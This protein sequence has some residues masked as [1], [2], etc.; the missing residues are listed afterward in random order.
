MQPTKQDLRTASVMAHNFTKHG[1]LFVPMP[2]TSEEDHHIL[3][4]QAQQRLDQLAAEA[5][6]EEGV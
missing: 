5:A 1:V 2:V 3:L 4:A 6:V